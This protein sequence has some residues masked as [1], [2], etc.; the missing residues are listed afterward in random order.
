[1]AERSPNFPT[2]SLP[3][4]VD[5]IRAIYQ[6]EGRAKMP[7]LS[8]VRPLGY[9]SING[10]SL[11]VLGALRAYGLLDGR[12]DDVRVSDD[13]ITILNAPSDSVERK[14][15]LVRAFESPAAFALLRS[16]GDASPDTLKWH[17]IKANFRNEAADKL[18]KVYLESR[19][20]VEASAGRLQFQAQEGGV[21]GNNR[22]KP[23]FG[24]LVRWENQGTVQFED[25]KVIGFSDDRDWAFVEGSPTGVPVAELEVVERAPP[26]PPPPPTFPR[27]I[28]TLGTVQ[29]Y[30]VVQLG[31][32]RTAIIEIKGG[33]P[34]PH[35]LAK[36]ERFIQLQRELLADSEDDVS[37]AR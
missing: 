18:L 15:A 14:D 36:L 10:R 30:F 37:V 11:G 9:T 34:T 1:M 25:R 27:Q 32:G 29:P 33:T 19:D 24:D 17:L 28:P 21:A 5:S 12:G 4:A 6:R 35:H 13:A 7:R 2:L 3:D 22:Q 8:A 26:A 16:K 31:D 20:F 23:R